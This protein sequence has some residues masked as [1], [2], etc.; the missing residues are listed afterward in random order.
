MK[1][2]ILQRIERLLILRASIFGR[3]GVRVVRLLVD[4]GS[5]YTILPNEV[6][7]SIGLDPS[8]SKERVKLTTGSG[9]IIAPRTEIRRFSCLGH[10]IK[11]FKV[12][13]H[14]LPPESFVDGLLAMDFLYH[15]KAVINTERG[16][17][18]VS[19]QG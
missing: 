16:E 19:S 4:T 8:M 6:L 1:K 13:T 18:E 10:T 12:V 11:N 3:K 5:T 9:Y 15:I 7:Y 2:Y 14:T 17:I